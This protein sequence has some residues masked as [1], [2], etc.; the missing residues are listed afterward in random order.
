MKNLRIAA[1]MLLIVGFSSTFAMLAGSKNKQLRQSISILGDS[2]STF[3]GNVEPDTNLV[4]YFNA[5]DT[6]RTDVNKVNQTWWYQLIKNNGYKL[7]KNNSYSGSTICNRGYFGADYTSFSF[8]ARARDLG[9]PD[10]ILVFGGTNDSWAGVPI[11]EYK[12]DTSTITTDDLYTFRP[13]LEKMM[14]TLTLRYPNVEIYCIVNDGLNSDIVASFHEICPI[15]GAEVIEL[16][17]IDKHS[18]HP[19]IIGMQQIAKQLADKLNK[20]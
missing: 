17:D 9:N 11:G 16:V 5:L 14:E 10:I 19:S 1:I 3:E 8:L 15:Y 18:G 13:A 20:R 7:A 4:W 6:A 2:Y 12:H